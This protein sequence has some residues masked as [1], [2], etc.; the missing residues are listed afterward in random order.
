MSGG[1]KKIPSTNIS[2]FSSA[3]GV[4]KI[5]QTHVFECFCQILK[6]EDRNVD[7]LLTLK[8]YLS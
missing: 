6:D 5:L 8:N 3:G 2:L 7:K 4:K 1:Q